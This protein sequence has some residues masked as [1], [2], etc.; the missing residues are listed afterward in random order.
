MISFTVNTTLPVR[1]A[2]DVTGCAGIP[3]NVTVAILPKVAL[4]RLATVIVKSCAEYA[5]PIRLP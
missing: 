1:P 2:T 5:P 4:P 3:E